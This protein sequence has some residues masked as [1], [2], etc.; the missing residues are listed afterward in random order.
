MM[1]FSKNI[2]TK[3]INQVKREPKA[4]VLK[5]PVKEE[6]AYIKQVEEKPA[7]FEAEPEV[8]EVLKKFQNSENQ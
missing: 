8:K 2:K 6:S 4:T 3:K 5:T 1:N 7:K